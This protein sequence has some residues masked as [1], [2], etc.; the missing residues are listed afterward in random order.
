MRPAGQY[1]TP[2]LGRAPGP[3]DCLLAPGP[4]WA[5]GPLDAREASLRAAPPVDPLPSLYIRAYHGI[6]RPARR[7]DSERFCLWPCTLQARLA[8]A[9]RQVQHALRD[10]ARPVPRR[11]RREGQGALNSR[12]RLNLIVPVSALVSRS[13][14]DL[15]SSFSSSFYRTPR[16]RRAA[17]P[18]SAGTGGARALAAGCRRVTASGQVTAH[19]SLSQVTGH[20]HRVH[21]HALYGITSRRP[22]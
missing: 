5:P 2:A 6:L 20:G 17:S 12:M 18:A 13:W 11:R 3:L 15:G 9:E 8:D 10:R 4:K 14:F 16:P 21:T 1:K 7:A 19:S 22:P